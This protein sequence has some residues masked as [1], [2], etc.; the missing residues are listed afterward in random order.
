[1]ELIYP[2]RPPHTGALRQLHL[3]DSKNTG[4]ARDCN[5]D[6]RRYGTDKARINRHGR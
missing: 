1:M 5:V 4:S 2:Y 6:I 3:A